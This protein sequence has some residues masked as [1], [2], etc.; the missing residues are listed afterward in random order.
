MH[1]EIENFV[2]GSREQFL[3]LL[4]EECKRWYVNEGAELRNT[5]FNKK[6]YL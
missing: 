3:F 6:P 5:Q 1:L 2:F 4:L